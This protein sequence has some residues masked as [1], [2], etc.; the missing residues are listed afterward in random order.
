MLM[1]PMNAKLKNIPK[2]L[3]NP[4]VQVMSGLK[5][6]DIENYFVEMATQKYE[7]LKISEIEQ[8]QNKIK[9]FAPIGGIELYIKNNQLKEIQN[10]PD[11]Y[12]CLHHRCLQSAESDVAQVAKLTHQCYDLQ[13]WKGYYKNDDKVKFRRYE[14]GFRL[15]YNKTRPATVLAKAELMLAE[16]DNMDIC[17]CLLSPDKSRIMVLSQPAWSLNDHPRTY[18]MA[19]IGIN[20][21]SFKLT[22]KVVRF[23]VGFTQDGTQRFAYFSGAGLELI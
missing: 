16:N 5:Q 11:F 3:E 23:F 4:D 13:H 18:T 21:A 6:S 10:L 14:A 9:A 15:L 12:T 19:L 17:A 2:T 20:D 22:D 8:F 1:R 7:R